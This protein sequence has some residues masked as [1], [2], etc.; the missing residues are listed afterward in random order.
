MCVSLICV[1]FTIGF[2]VILICIIV[3]VILTRIGNYNSYMMF[4]HFKDKYNIETDNYDKQYVDI[5]NIIENDK[6]MINN[7]VKNIIKNLGDNVPK[8]I[9]DM[10]CGIGYYTNSFL[11][12]G[13]NV[14]EVVNNFYMCKHLSFIRFANIGIL[15]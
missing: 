2:G 11:E 7:D 14:I 4:E 10:G 6:N 13:Y 1:S 12:N 9:I 5:C 8:K 3:I 15:F